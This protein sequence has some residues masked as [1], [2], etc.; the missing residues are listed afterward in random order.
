MHLIATSESISLDALR[1][2]ES[3]PTSNEALVAV[4]VTTAHAGQGRA[5]EGEDDE[6]ATVACTEPAAQ[7]LEVMGWVIASQLE[8]A[9]TA[10]TMSEEWV[11]L[12]EDGACEDRYAPLI[13]TSQLFALLFTSISLLQ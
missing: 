5:A 6:E 8:S 2:A 12:L 10:R 13:A 9:S 11:R 3:A 1:I 7:A 4:T